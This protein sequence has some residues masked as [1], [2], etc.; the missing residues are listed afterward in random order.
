MPRNAPTMIRAISPVSRFLPTI[1]FGRAR[2]MR[3]VR[4]GAIAWDGVVNALHLPCGVPEV[5][6]DPLRGEGAV[7]APREP[8]AATPPLIGL[9]GRP[10][11]LPPSEPLRP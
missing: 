3:Y 10:P 7:E 9:A 8:C 6:A 1:A 4:R 2:P 5:G 11:L